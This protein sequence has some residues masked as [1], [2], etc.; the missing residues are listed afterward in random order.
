MKNYIYN[1]SKVLDLKVSLSLSTKSNNSGL[2]IQSNR[3][4]LPVC[5]PCVRLRVEGAQLNLIRLIVL[6]LRKGGRGL[7]QQIKRRNVPF[8]LVLH[9]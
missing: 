8:L 9:L 5:E 4:R 1:S 7:I 6:L 3:S 2:L